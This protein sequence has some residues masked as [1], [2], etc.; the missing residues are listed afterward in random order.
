[1]TTSS[2]LALQLATNTAIM[3]AASA[4]RARDELDDEPEGESRDYSPDP[5]ETE[6][7]PRWKVGVIAAAVAFLL[8]I[9]FCRFG[10]PALRRDQ[11][12]GQV[13]ELPYRIEQDGHIFEIDGE[14][15]V[16]VNE[17]GTL[18]LPLGAYTVREVGIEEVA[19]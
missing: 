13:V 7:R 8:G 14:A 16:R 17:D 11:L 12:Q 19:K 4:A 2:M 1:M 9:G 3:A 5:W 15:E 10:W 6:S 18:S